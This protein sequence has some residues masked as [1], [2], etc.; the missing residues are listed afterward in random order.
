MF[1]EERDYYM[2]IAESEMPTSL[3]V[4]LK[5]ENFL[6]IS[7]LN[8]ER[9]AKSVKRFK[10]PDH[11]ASTNRLLLEMLKAYDDTRSDECINAAIDIAAWLYNEEASDYNLLNWYQSVYRKNPNDGAIDYSRLRLIMDES[12]DIKA[13]AGAAIIS[14]DY[15]KAK[16]M[17]ESMTEDEKT[18]FTQFPIYNMLMVRST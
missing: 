15:D 8:Y 4:I 6:R 11:Y 9:I 7:N 10:N 13:I 3:Y 16:T 12:E 1:D 5:K 14:G 17:I 18:E 2:T